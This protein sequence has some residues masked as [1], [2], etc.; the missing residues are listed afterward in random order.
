MDYYCEVCD[1]FIKPKN[2]YKHF[3]SNS[4]EEFDKCEHIILSLEDIDKN[5][6]NEA[7]GLY[8]IKRNK[9]F[10]FYLVKCHLKLVFTDYQCCP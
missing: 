2:K 10:D 4:H 5:Q 6:V 9:K 1:I 7:F 3:K 8:I